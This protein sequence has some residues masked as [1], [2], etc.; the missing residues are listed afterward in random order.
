VQRGCYCEER[1]QE[2]VKMFFYSEKFK[3]CIAQIKVPVLSTIN[4]YE[5]I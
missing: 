2:E 3:I 5:Q 1:G 4:T